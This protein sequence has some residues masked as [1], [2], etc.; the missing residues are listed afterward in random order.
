MSNL[1]TLTMTRSPP[2]LAMFSQFLPISSPILSDLAKFSRVSANFIRLF[3]KE[4]PEF[5]DKIKAGESTL[6]E[7]WF[8]PKPSHNKPSHLHV[9]SWAISLSEGFRGISEQF[10]ARS[11][12]P[13]VL[14]CRIAVQG[15]IPGTTA[16][17]SNSPKFDV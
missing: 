10:R 6:I 16:G 14:K 1:S 17:R 15:R 2:F 3:S 7:T 5:F 12:K 9:W 4:T 13:F 11:P 8:T